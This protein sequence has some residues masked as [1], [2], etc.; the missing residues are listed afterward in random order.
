MYKAARKAAGLSIEEAA[1]R[2][3]IGNRTLFNYENGHTLVPPEVAL[4]MA[5]VYGQPALTARYCAEECAIGQ[6][7]AYPVESKNLPALVLGVIKE[8]NDVRQIRDKLI[9]LAADGEITEQEMPEFQRVLDELMDLE[10]K[11]EALKLW[12]ARIVPVAAMIRRRKE[13]AAV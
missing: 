7:Y 9:E 8:Q 6:A 3:H 12:A 11:I 5:E 10:Q 4:K 2:L 13:K 1:W